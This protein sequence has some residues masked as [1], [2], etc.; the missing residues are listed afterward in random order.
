VDKLTKAAMKALW[1]KFDDKNKAPH[2]WTKVEEVF[3]LDGKKY[4]V[5]A[6][7]KD[8]T[9]QPIASHLSVQCLEVKKD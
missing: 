5:S 8:G 7:V 4:K 6:Q 1:S 2:K 9:D 3:E